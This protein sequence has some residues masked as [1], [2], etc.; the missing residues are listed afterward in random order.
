MVIT[1]T[2]QKGGVS[3]TTTA[4]LMG[5]GLRRRGFTTM[6]IDLDPQ[7]SMSYLLQADKTKPSVYELLNEEAA[8]KEVIQAT[9]AGLLFIAGSPKMTAMTGN[10]TQLAI[11]NILDPIRGIADFIILDTPPA[12]SALTVAATIAADK[13]IIPTQAGSMALSGIMKLY[14][15]AIVMAQ[16]MNPQ[17]AIDGILLTRY[18]DRT[19][20]NRQLKALL[21][22]IAAACNTKV[23]E[24]TIRQGIAVEE[25]QAAQTDLFQYAPAAPVTKDYEN[26]I[27]EF[28]R[29]Q[30]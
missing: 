12:L 5:A 15:S 16:K 14:T 7:A 20:I 8:I 9:P 24:T 13:I 23:Y 27:D 10:I 21:A 4:W 29:G 30:K 22:D 25:A 1:M 6:L 28:L 2:N 17:L 3:K 19:V 26:F 11:K 18:T